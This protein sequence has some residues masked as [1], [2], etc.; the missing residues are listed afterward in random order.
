MAAM[1]I[2]GKFAAALK[3][4]DEDSR[5]MPFFCK[6]VI[7]IIIIGVA[8]RLIIGFFMTYVFDIYHWGVVIQNIN[9]G[10]GLYELTGYFY[11]PPWGYL[12]GSEALFQDLLGITT[13][14]TRP[15]EALLLE[16][17]EGFYLGTVTTIP[18]NMAMKLMFIISDLIVG[19]LIFWLIRDITKD[20]RKAVVGFA[21]W[22]L[23]PFVITVGQITVQFDTISVLIT[24]LA[25]IM[26]RKDRYIESGVLLCIAAL[27]KLFPG[28]F[29]FIFIAYII[30][31][32]RDA[33]AKGK[34]AMFLGAVAVTAFI[35]FLP[36][37]L[38]GT[39][40]SAFSFITSRVSE[41]TGTSTLASFGGYVALL[42]YIAAAVVAVILALRIKNDRNK[43]G[44]DALLFDSLQI[45]TVVMFLHPPLP[46]YVL[47]LLP[48][49]LFA[50][51]SEPR[52]RTACYLLM[53]GTTLVTL[54]GWPMN[55]AALTFHTG[56]LDT[57]LWTDMVNGIMTPVFGHP[58]TDYLGTIG[59]VTQYLGILYAGWVRF[60]EDIKRILR[61]RADAK[62]AAQ[63]PPA[64]P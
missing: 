4:K 29:I 24:L 27:L 3:E 30:A 41:G 26:L 7:L 20:R 43:E 36:Q 59:Y 35:L 38:D 32:N 33:G 62:R 21:F 28:F 63:R 16:V 46:Q 11:T 25:V 34:A 37:L 57:G 55:L 9:S 39:V 5:S 40:A 18:F 50:M 22:F 31:K 44:L 60:G 49:L 56:M 17:I 23:C 58:I 13:I 2:F 51:T 53:I 1:S 14:G 47:L 15:T 12:L 45:L 19:Y 48:F 10:N 8:A 42:A 61:E 64:S 54:V 6:Y 52:Y